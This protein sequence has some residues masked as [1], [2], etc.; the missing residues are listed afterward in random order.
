MPQFLQL[1]LLTFMRNKEYLLSHPEIHAIGQPTLWYWYIALSFPSGL[2][3]I[4][5]SIIRPKGQTHLQKTFPKTTP[6][7]IPASNTYH[8]EI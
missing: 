4:M 2:D 8:R 5:N 3:P 1:S 7:T 6:K